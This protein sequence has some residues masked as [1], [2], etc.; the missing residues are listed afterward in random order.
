MNLIY[1]ELNRDG[2]PYNGKR[3]NKYHDTKFDFIFSAYGL[4]YILMPD[5]HRFFT[6]LI[7]KLLRSY[8]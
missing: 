5:I 6:F 8:K 1:Q 2:L 7:I 4:S 3:L